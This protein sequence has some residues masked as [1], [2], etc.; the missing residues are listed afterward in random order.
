LLSLVQAVDKRKQRGGDRKSEE[1][2]SNATS[3]A[4]DKRSSDQTANLAGTDR[5]KVEKIRAI[6]DYAKAT[7]DKASRLT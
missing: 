1:A 6:A 3:V 2:K 7:G 5:G 4:I